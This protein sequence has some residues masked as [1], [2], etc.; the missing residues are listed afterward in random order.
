MRLYLGSLDRRL[1]V[2][3]DIHTA[4]HERFRAAGIEIAFPQLDVRFRGP[5]PG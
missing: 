4:I 1:Y 5:P 2:I 3:N